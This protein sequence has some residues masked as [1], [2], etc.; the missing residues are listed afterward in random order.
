M[1]EGVLQ[2]E[3]DHV[4]F[5]LKRVDLLEILLHGRGD[6]VHGAGHLLVAVPDRPAQEGKAVLQRIRTKSS[7]AGAAPTE[8]DR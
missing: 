3:E 8:P 6:V 1:R 2:A 5:F 4:G 7:S